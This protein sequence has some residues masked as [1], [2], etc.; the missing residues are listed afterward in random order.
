MLVKIERQHTTPSGL[1]LSAA[2]GIQDSQVQYGHRGK[3]LA[4]GPGKRD[5][6][7]IRQPLS[8]RPG[9]TVRFGEFEY[10]KLDGDQILIQEADI[11]GIEE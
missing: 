8:V 11:A 9:V 10:K 3:V 6:H 4:I 5:K 1:L 7:G 2:K